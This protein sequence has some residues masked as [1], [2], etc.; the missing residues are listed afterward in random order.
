MH[1]LAFIEILNCWNFKVLKKRLIV[2]AHIASNSSDPHHENI[3]EYLLHN[4][5]GR[6]DDD[7]ERESQLDRQKN[8]YN[9]IECTPREIL[10]YV[11]CGCKYYQSYGLA[12][13]AS[14]LLC[15]CQTLGSHREQRAD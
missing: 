4:I 8:P 6:F 3:V 2:N 10:K 7:G 5:S 11:S 1:Y 15:H 12:K 14:Y 13:D 9:V